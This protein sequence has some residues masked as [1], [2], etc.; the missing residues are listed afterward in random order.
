[1]SF[2]TAAG[3][4]F[5]WL[6]ENSFRSLEVGSDAPNGATVLLYDAFGP[7]GGR[8]SRRFHASSMGAAWRLAA[9]AIQ[10]GKL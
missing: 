5:A 7:R 10:T 4:V 8:E 9:D 1:M 6:D 2:E 3:I